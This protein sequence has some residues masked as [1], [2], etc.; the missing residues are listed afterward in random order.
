MDIYW[1][2]HVP[3]E[4]LGSIRPWAENKGHKL[5][6]TRL[7][8]EDELPDPD[9]VGM[10]IIMG[11]PMGVHDEATFSWLAEEKKFIARVLDRNRPIMGIC[12]GAQLLAAVMNLFMVIG[13]RQKKRL[14]AEVTT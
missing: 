2:Q 3:F 1:L 5:I 4:G 8:A 6:A 14:L 9:D 7:W 12:L 13:Y 10:L 11:G